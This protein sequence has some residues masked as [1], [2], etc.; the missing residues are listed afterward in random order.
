MITVRGNVAWARGLLL[1]QMKNAAGGTDSISFKILY[2]FRKEG[3]WPTPQG[4]KL[5]ARQAVK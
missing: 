2:V 3:G 4:W 5:L 1:A